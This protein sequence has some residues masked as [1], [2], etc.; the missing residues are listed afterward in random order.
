MKKQSFFG[1]RSLLAMLALL[2]AFPPLS[3]DLYLPALPR[4]MEAMQ[5]TQGPVNL[6]L[7]LFLVFFAAGILIWVLSA[8]NTAENPFF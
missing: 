7:S 3:T 2:S 8:R 1:D 4:V 6:S 5:T